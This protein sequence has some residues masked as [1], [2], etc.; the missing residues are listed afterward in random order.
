MQILCQD[1]FNSRPV[2]STRKKAY[3]REGIHM[4][5]K[6]VKIC[7][8]Y[9]IIKP[10]LFQVCGK[11]F[12]YRQ[13]LITHSTLHTGIKPYQCENCGNSF[14]CVG[15][16]LKHRKW[17]PDTCGSVPS[18]THRMNNPSTKIKV[19]VNTPSSSRL[20]KLSKKDKE[21]KEKLNVLEE[22]LKTSQTKSKNLIS[23]NIK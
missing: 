15:N 16:L 4:Q 22:K 5:C 12:S 7:L 17:H 21:I 23:G 2:E 6:I 8:I 20:L 9:I 14:S 3:T 13:S 19:K 1:V 11:G 10:V 18:T